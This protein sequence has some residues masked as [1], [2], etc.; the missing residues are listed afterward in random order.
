[1]PLASITHVP[2]RTP[3]RRL[4]R[5]MMGAA[6]VCGVGIT[7][8][9]VP[10]LS[11]SAT[12]TAQPAAVSPQGSIAFAT[13]AGTAAA[14]VPTYTTL[15]QNLVFSGSTLAPAWK[16]YDNSYSKDPAVARTRVKSLVTL[17]NGALKVT[18]KYQSGSGLCL[19]GAGS[20][21]T[22]PYGRW[23]IRARITA[24]ADHSAAVLLWPTTAPWPSG[25]EIDILESWKPD[26]STS[27]FTVHYGADNEQI[28]QSTLN[29]VTQL[30]TYSV[31]WTPTYINYWIDGVFVKSITDPAAIPSKPMFLAL[32]AGPHGSSPSNSSASM[33]VQSVKVYGPR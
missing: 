10:T 7:V 25:G 17:Q 4:H 12:P 9:L 5:R 33:I 6:V 11:A 26:R 15:R 32:Q 21:P 13:P 18:S 19:C 31:E 20:K 22:Q 16:V 30:H 1:M 28:M 23:D 2:G 29:D 14:P 24:N 8:A 27:V 3:R